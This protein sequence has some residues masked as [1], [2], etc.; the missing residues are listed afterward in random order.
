MK[1]ISYFL[2]VS[3]FLE[4]VSR[5]YFPEGGVRNKG[6]P[7]ILSRENNKALSLDDTSPSVVIWSF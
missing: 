6:R 5:T 1:G 3:L 2:L 4:L 7:K